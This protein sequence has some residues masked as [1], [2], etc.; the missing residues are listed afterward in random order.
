MIVGFAVIAIISLIVMAL[1]PEFFIVGI[2]VLFGLAIWFGIVKLGSTEGQTMITKKTVIAGVVILLVS[3]LLATT[4]LAGW[5]SFDIGGPD[6]NDYKTKEYNVNGLIGMGTHTDDG[7]KDE[8]N[9]DHLYVAAWT[10]GDKSEKIVIQGKVK[11]DPWG[12][13]G[14]VDE[15][16]YRIFLATG[17]DWGDPVAEFKNLKPI[18][19]DI[20]V[21][22]EVVYEH[23]IYEIVGS[24]DGWMQVQFR[25]R[26]GGAFGGWATLA[27]DYARIQTGKGDINFAEGI[28]EV[29]DMAVLELDLGYAK[30]QYKLEVKALTSGEM[31][32]DGFVDES[33]EGKVTTM[34]FPVKASHV[35]IGTWPDC[36]DNLIEAKLWN[37]LVEKAQHETAVTDIKTLGPEKPTIEL[38]SPKD[39][40]AY[41]TGEAISIKINAKPN[42]Q[43]Q[44]PIKEYRLHISPGD[45]VDENADGTFSF[46][47]AHRGTFKL[48]YSCQ[49]AV[50]RRSEVVTKE[51]TVYDEG[52]DPGIL[53][54]DF[55]WSTI[56]ILIAGLIAFL[57]TVVVAKDKKVSTT[58][59]ILF[60]A[61]A[62]II[63]IVIGLYFTGE[64]VI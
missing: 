35:G 51:I 13:G 1:K 59:S 58:K 40:K 34:E 14:I 62:S 6:I 10:Q 46:Q 56:L 9:D 37:E 54:G 32:F 5:I 4:I 31:L 20:Q 8:I 39:G 43:T 45:I 2:I 44:A 7:E 18:M 26:F 64:I 38:S 41:R 47:P 16:A 50:C 30:G 19:G 27:R 28:Y 61:V 12:F 29:G 48:M 22:D 33:R 60:G 23:K 21:D 36:P 57:I 11:I 3:I 55:P 63:V 52:E 49:D 24:F 25:I 53:P 42:L 17:D 15:G